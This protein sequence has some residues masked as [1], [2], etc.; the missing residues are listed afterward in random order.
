VPRRPNAFRISA[1]ISRPGPEAGQSGETLLNDWANGF[2]IAI[3]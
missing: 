1:M 3:K 2:I